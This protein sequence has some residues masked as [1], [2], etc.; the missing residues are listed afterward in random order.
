MTEWIDVVPVGDIEDGDHRLVEA[1]DT[2]VA[3]FNLGGEYFAVENLC[4]H[5]DVPIADGEIDADDCITCPIHDAQFC[6]RTG[7]VMAPP[8][9]DP[10]TRFPVRVEGTMIQVGAQPLD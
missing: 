2:E 3:V 7:A 10:L 5:E 4:T 1:A 9:E 8:A 6:L